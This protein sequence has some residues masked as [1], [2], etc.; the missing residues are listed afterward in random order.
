MNPHKHFILLVGGSGTRLWPFSRSF[1]PKQFIGF[2]LEKTLIQETAARLREIFPG[3]STKIFAV[4]HHENIFEVSRQL[5]PIVPAENQRVLAEPER[6]NT[7]PAIAWSVAQVEAE[8]PNALV[9]VFPSD[10]HIENVPNLKSDL[11]KAFEIAQ[12]SFLVTLGIRPRHPETGYGYLRIG[13]KLKSGFSVAGF[14]EKPSLE[15]AKTY[16]SSGDYYWNSG[17][18]VF[19]VQAFQSEL[20]KR[21]PEIHRSIQA[22]IASGNDAQT[23]KEEYARLKNLSIDYGLMEKAERV[24][25]VPA[26]FEWSDLGGWSSVFDIL[27][28][29]ENQNAV[30]GDV[31]SY[32]TRSSLLISKKGTLATI[33]LKDMV[34]AQTD[35]A[36]LVCPKERSQDVKKIVELLKDRKNPVIDYHP[37]VRRPW[38]TFTVLEEGPCFKIKKITVDPG[39]RLSLQR[40]RHRA[41]HWVVVEGTAQV[42]CGGKQ[43]TLTANESTYISPGLKHRLENPGT[44]PLSIIEVQTGSYVGEDDIERFEDVYGRK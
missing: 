11:E 37:T 7:L 1:A 41:E 22:I 36:V 10:H 8:D 9:A 20:K 17:I 42:T 44:S 19:S 16:L 38:G 26:S 21:E 6:K 4:T 29:D 40:H 12:D 32:D 2:K 28:K 13:E 30:Q 39:Q 23:A 3:P 27:P 43:Y 31:V 24:A 35:D 33:G 5:A 18:F 25:M 15:K 14:S 34:V